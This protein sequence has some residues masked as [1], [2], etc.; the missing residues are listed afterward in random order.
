MFCVYFSGKEAGLSLTLYLSKTYP[1]L[2]RILANESFEKR[3]PKNALLSI[4]KKE[5]LALNQTGLLITFLLDIFISLQRNW[6]GFWILCLHGLQ[7]HVVECI[8][9]SNKRFCNL[10]LGVNYSE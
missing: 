6:G 3:L 10:V 4:P 1:W 2:I 9:K 8:S 7:F 5:I